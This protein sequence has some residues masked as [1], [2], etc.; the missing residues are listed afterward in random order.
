MAISRDWKVFLSSPV[1][2]L[3]EFR[4]KAR[5]AIDGMEGFHVV[6]QEQFGARGWKSVE[7]CVSK[8][9]SS[10]VLV[11]LVG[12]MYGS[13]PD[14]E[15]RSYSIV[16]FETAQ[17]NSIQCLMLMLPEGMRLPRA[18]H[19]PEPMLKRQAEFA[20]RINAKCTRG[21]VRT[22]DEFARKTMQALH[23]WERDLLL[24]SDRLGSLSS[25]FDEQRASARKAL[26][27]HGKPAFMELRATPSSSS[28]PF[29]SKTLRDTATRLQL[30]S[31]AF[32][33]AFV[34]DGIRRRPE[35]TAAGVRATRGP[36]VLNGF[37]YFDYWY[38]RKDGALYAMEGTYE[39]GSDLAAGIGWHHRA[40]H[41]RDALLFLLE[42][43]TALGLDSTDRVTAK[44]THG[45]LA[46]KRVF[47]PTAWDARLRVAATEDQIET[48]VVFRLADL[49]ER[50]ANIVESI[51]APLLELFDGFSLADGDLARY[52]HGG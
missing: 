5:E 33:V 20:R 25:W 26:G 51:T 48:E 46:G 17:A 49:R 4:T 35:F 41:V 31:S 18:P 2:G 32:G 50:N 27:D 1:R 7:V 40:R 19:E 39:E 28:G 24:Q 13:L 23:N 14:G 9:Q 8:V 52:L 10:D 21:I 11:G 42:F 34:P 29:T 37:R 16:E 47:G 30:L 15:E 22:P 43:Y 36:E 6:C 44:F 3:E 12:P 45:G 38:I